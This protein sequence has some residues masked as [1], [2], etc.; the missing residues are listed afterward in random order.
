ME[1]AVR[2]FEDW[3]FRVL[4]QES[5]MDEGRGGAGQ[6]GDGQGGGEGE[7]EGGDQERRASL[8]QDISC[9]LLAVTTAQVTNRLPS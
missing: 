9:Q 4:E 5:G 6:D 7:G 3:E 2:A 8:E 1:A